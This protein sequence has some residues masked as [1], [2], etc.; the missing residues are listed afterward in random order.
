LYHRH[1]TFE[2]VMHMNVYAFVYL[3]IRMWYMWNWNMF[4]LCVICIFILDPLVYPL[5][6]NFVHVSTHNNRT[7]ATY[8]MHEMAILIIHIVIWSGNLMIN[9]FYMPHIGDDPNVFGLCETLLN[10]DI[11]L[12]FTRLSY[13]ILI[14]IFW[15][16]ED[17]CRMW[18]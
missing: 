3:C 9:K 5:G 4:I 13:E 12:W 2:C 11:H 16:N 15:Y 14:W 6:V 18:N 8:K 7:H 10:L 17:N 1:I